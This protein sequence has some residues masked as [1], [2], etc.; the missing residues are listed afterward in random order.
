MLCTGFAIGLDMFPFGGVGYIRMVGSPSRAILHACFS[1]NCTTEEHQKNQCYE[2]S[3]SF[4][5]KSVI[6]S[7][8]VVVAVITSVSLVYPC[9]LK[10]GLSNLE[11]VLCYT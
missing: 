2:E 10:M 3:D 1:V 4:F 5:H 6:L 8:S 11:L 7:C 9:F